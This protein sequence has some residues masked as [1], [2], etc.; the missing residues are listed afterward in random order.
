MHGVVLRYDHVRAVAGAQSIID[1]GG[2][3]VLEVCVDVP[4]QRWE[5]RVLIFHLSAEA[6]A[7][8]VADEINYEPQR[9]ARLTG[10]GRR[11]L[12]P[13]PAMGS[14]L[15]YV[16]EHPAPAPI[17]AAVTARSRTPRRRPTTLVR[18]GMNPIVVTVGPSHTLREAARRMT[19]RGVGA[20]VV[21]DEAQPGPCIITERDIL[22]SNGVGQ[23]IDDELV[24]EH[25][26]SEVVYAAADWSLEKAAAA[27]VRGGFRHIIVMDGSEVSGIL[28]MRDVVRCWTSDGATCE[29]EDES[30]L[31]RS[32]PA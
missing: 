13:D 22:H 26:T 9:D 27:M 14:H 24:S 2:W 6:V 28:S 5:A 32:A 29:L 18:D 21:I 12:R 31:E 10:C 23:G 4:S 19:A 16:A 15:C 8:T 17:T 25:L 3:C 1:E 7:D 20:A 11:T 30:R